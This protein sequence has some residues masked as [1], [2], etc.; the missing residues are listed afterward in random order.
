MTEETTNNSFP[1]IKITSTISYLLDLNKKAGFYL[2]NKTGLLKSENY[3]DNELFRIGG[4]SS[5]R[6]FNEQSIFVKN[7]TLQNIEYRYATSSDSYLYTITDLAII[8]TNQNKE[9]LY[10]LG[11]GYLF[12][13]NNSQINISTAVGTNTKNPLDFK[14][15]QFFVNWVNFF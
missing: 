7:Y 5:I 8:S 15:T 11:I 3:F 4:S 9:K 14:N 2:R 10:S 13:T 12:N 1:Q 6:G